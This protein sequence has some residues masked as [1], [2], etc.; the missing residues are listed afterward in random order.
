MTVIKDISP[1][2]SEERI[3]CNTKPKVKIIEN[4]EETIMSTYFM[5]NC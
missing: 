4:N 5:Q 3:F 1:T 2:T